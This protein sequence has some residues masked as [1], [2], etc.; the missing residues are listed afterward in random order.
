MAVTVGGSFATIGK[1]NIN[2]SV[3]RLGESL[4]KLSS[5]KKINKAADNAAGLAIAEQ[6]S[7]DIRSANQAQRNINDGVS[8]T[9]VAEGGLS[10]ISNL[11]S[12]GRELSIQAANGTLNDQQRST[13][14]QEITAIKE[15]VD[16]ITGV[17]EFNGQK[18]IDGSQS[19]GSSNQT[20]IQAGIN[21][22]SDDRISTNV[23]EDSGTAAL[24]IDSVDISTQAGAQSALASFDNAIANVSANRANIGALQNRLDH[25]AR[26]VGSQAEALTAAKS[27]IMDLDYAKE[28]TNFSTNQT[29]NQASISALQQGMSVQQGIVGALL[30]VKG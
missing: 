18:L 12:R 6:L 5:G 24:G 8:M 19:S 16:R 11:M 30:N 28:S 1:N 25:A 10:E 7:A 20:S 21:S 23:V 4:S 26:N 14:N 2:S 3:N 17:T 9:R 29:L 27:Q 15:E 22:T 13:L